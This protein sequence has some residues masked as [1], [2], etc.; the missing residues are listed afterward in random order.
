MEVRTGKKEPAK[1]ITYGCLFSFVLRGCA[2]PCVW[3]ILC[4][5]CW[6]RGPL[7][8]CSVFCW[9][10][11][12]YG[13]VWASRTLLFFSSHVVESQ[14]LGTQGHRDTVYTAWPRKDSPDLTWSGGS[15]RPVATFSP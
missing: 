5:C 14:Q 2:I 7:R 3:H 1:R 10:A 8:T 15:I 11:Y 4:W 6:I 9:L 13:L 12:Y